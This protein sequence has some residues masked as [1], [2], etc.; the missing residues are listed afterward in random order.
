VDAD[1]AC[2]NYYLF[3]HDVDGWVYW[4]SAS[5]KRDRLGCKHIF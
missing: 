2:T 3:L 4:S 5:V 1:G